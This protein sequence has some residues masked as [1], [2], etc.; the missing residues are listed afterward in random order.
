MKGKRKREVSAA[1]QNGSDF[2]TTQFEFLF[3]NDTADCVE[4]K[5]ICAISCYI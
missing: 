1:N 4:S 2:C 5:E 3:D